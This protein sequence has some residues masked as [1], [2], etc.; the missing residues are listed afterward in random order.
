[1]GITLWL[2]GI[3]QSLFLT[4]LIDN[5]IS[6]AEEMVTTENAVRLAILKGVDPEEAYLEHGKF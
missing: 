5:V 4:G 6:I 3:Q 2:T 1:M